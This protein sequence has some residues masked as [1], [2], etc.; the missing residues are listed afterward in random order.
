MKTNLKLLG[1]FLL[2]LFSFLVFTNQTSNLSEDEILTSYEY[3]H[4]GRTFE[5]NITEINDNT[6][7][8]LNYKYVKGNFNRF[9]SIPF[10]YSPYDL[11]YMYME[12]LSEF[13]LNSEVIYISRDHSLEELTDSKDGIAMLTLARVL[14]S[15]MDPDIYEFPL[16]IALTSYVEG[17]HSPIVGCEYS[18]P[19]ARVIE[20]RVG[21]KDAV[22]KEGEYCVVME[23]EEGT[24]PIKVAT[25]LT[26]HVLGVM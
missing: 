25:K 20:L 14:D 24:D 11:E 8:V 2:F 22:Y 21:N 5:F 4:A 7:H 6:R 26:Y 17:I 13:I 1:L 10:R 12:E 15:E 18:N 9:A 23:F 16:A 3:T 19:E